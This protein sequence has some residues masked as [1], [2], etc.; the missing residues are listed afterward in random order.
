[1]TSRQVFGLLSGICFVFLLSATCFVFALIYVRRGHPNDH[2]GAVY[3]GTLCTGSLFAF[4]I[5]LLV[6]TGSATFRSQPA[7]PSSF[8]RLMR[9]SA[10]VFVLFVTSIGATLLFN[11]GPPGFHLLT[12]CVTLLLIATWEKRVRFSGTFLVAKCLIRMAA[13][14]IGLFAMSVGVPLLSMAA[15][16]YNKLHL[17]WAVLDLP[18]ADSIPPNDSMI[19]GSGLFG[20]CYT[21]IGCLLLLAA[22]RGFQ[23][24]RIRLGTSLLD[25]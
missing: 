10:F 22:F 3:W 24:T 17:H 19:L 11:G 9:N 18:R 23:I 1:M 12:P 7:S 25:P 5:L 14:V 16:L 15:V 2:L 8:R 13:F 4:M 20:V 21:G 6:A